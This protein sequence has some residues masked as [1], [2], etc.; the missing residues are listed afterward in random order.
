MDTIETAFQPSSKLDAPNEIP[1]Q[2]LPEN[3]PTMTQPVSMSWDRWNTTENTYGA[4]TGDGCQ[5][6]FFGPIKSFCLINGNRVFIWCVGQGDKKPVQFT[7]DADVTAFGMLCFIDRYYV[8]VF[9]TGTKMQMYHVRWPDYQSTMIECVPAGEINCTCPDDVT[10]FTGYGNGKALFGTRTGAVYQFTTTIQNHCFDHGIFHRMECLHWEWKRYAGRVAPVRSLHID[11]T[12]KLGYALHN[13]SEINVFALEPGG[14]FSKPIRVGNWEKKNGPSLTTIQSLPRVGF[15]DCALM[16][17]TP[18]GECLFFYLDPSVFEG[19]KLKPTHIAKK[20]KT[21]CGFGLNQ[22]LEIRHRSVVSPEYLGEFLGNDYIMTVA[23]IFDAT[24]VLNGYHPGS[25]MSAL[26]ELKITINGSH[27]LSIVPHSQICGRIEGVM[28][29]EEPYDHFMAAERK[30]DQ[31]FWDDELS[32]QMFYNETDIVVFTQKHYF[33]MQKKTHCQTLENIIQTETP[34]MLERFQESYSPLETA[35]M[36]VYLRVCEY[37]V[38]RPL[39]T[40]PSLLEQVIPGIYLCLKRLF[41][42]IWEKTVIELEPCDFMQI[43]KTDIITVKLEEEEI[44][45][46]FGYMKAFNQMLTEIITIV[47]ITIYKDESM[48]CPPNAIVTSEQAKSFVELRDFV[49]KLF[50]L[51]KFLKKLKKTKKAKFSLKKCTKKEDVMAILNLNFRDF[52]SFAIYKTE[53]FLKFIKEIRLQLR[54]SKSYG[55]DQFLSKHAPFLREQPAEEMNAQTTEGNPSI[56]T[57]RITLMNERLHQIHESEFCEVTRKRRIHEHYND[58]YVECDE[59]MKLFD[60]TGASENFKEKFKE[61]LTSVKTINDQSVQDNIWER[62]LRGNFAVP[63]VLILDPLFEKL[64][65]EK[66]KDVLERKRTPLKLNK[67]Q[68]LAADTLLDLLDVQRRSIEVVELHISLALRQAHRTTEET[69]LLER[70]GHLKKAMMI[71]KSNGKFME[72]NHVQ[73]MINNLT[74]QN[75]IVALLRERLANC[76]VDEADRNLLRQ[77]ETGVVSNWFLINI[78]KACLMDNDKD[79]KEAFKNSRFKNVDTLMNELK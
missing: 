30:P 77:L 24:I 40:T 4:F 64:L 11:S 18:E 72:S 79:T 76:V 32:R 69:G 7:F 28:K 22:N 35:A 56:L 71:F 3:Y 29:T 25:E 75:E 10:A 1:I 42:P 37:D 65:M 39:I 51:I 34:A 31:L 55:M 59:L 60:S 44:E 52:T 20:A 58:V 26:F 43:K 9:I 47:G 16:G 68:L 63:S 8:L 48:F 49:G 19:W 2:V 67:D 15:H 5:C 17:C 14:L 21:Y 57:Q 50:S 6:T 27:D 53:S 23:G 38:F 74:R 41:D 78:V 12:R 66:L 62:I 33:K 54:T 61:Y 36:I 73:R 70:I 45:F 13:N 46:Y